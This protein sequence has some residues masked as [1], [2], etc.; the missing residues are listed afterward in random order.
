MNDNEEYRQGSGH[1][2]GPPVCTA[3]VVTISNADKEVGPKTRL[4][5][6]T[7]SSFKLDPSEEIF[8]LFVTRQ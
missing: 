3:I 6:C 8:W 5:V 7:L 1:E 2:A 4:P